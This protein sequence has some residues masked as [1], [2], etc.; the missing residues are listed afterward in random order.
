MDRGVSLSSMRYP[1]REDGILPD[2][3]KIP[4]IPTMNLLFARSDLRKGLLG[5]AIIDT[6]FDA[7]IYANQ[8]LVEFLANSRVKRTTSLQAAGYTVTCEV[9]D[10]ECHVTDQ[11]SKPI[12]SLGVVEA[13][14]PVDPVDLSEDVIVGRLILNR[15]SL[16]LNGR[17]AELLP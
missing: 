17:I 9:F 4:D 6:G 5:E 1:Y 2:G 14:C 16:N 7:A 3:F 8:D 11:A 12:L 10:I 13:Y 15:L